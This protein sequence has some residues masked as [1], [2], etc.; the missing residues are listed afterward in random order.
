MTSKSRL[1]SSAT[2]NHTSNF[3]WKPT[4]TGEAV[5]HWFNDDKVSEAVIPEELDGRPVVAAESVAFSCCKSLRSLTL[6]SS[7]RG[8]LSSA[9]A[10]VSLDADLCQRLFGALLDCPSLLKLHVDPKNTRFR[11]VDGVLLTDDGRTLYCF[12]QGRTGDYV[13]PP[14]VERIAPNAFDSCRLT[15]VAF[16]EELRLIDDWAFFKSNNLQTLDFGTKSSLQKIGVRAFG[17][18]AVLKRVTLPD[19][20]ETLDESAFAYSHSL[21]EVILNRS[22]KEIGDGAFYCCDAL[23]QISFGDRL[24]RI[25]SG[26]FCGCSSLTQVV[27][28]QKLYQIGVDAFS[29]CK[30]LTQVVLPQALRKIGASAFEGCKALSSVAF[31]DS[32][33]EIGDRAFEGCKPLTKISLPESLQ[34]INPQTFNACPNLTAF[35]VSPR[36]RFFQVVDGS[37]LSADGKTLWRVPPMQMGAFVVPNGVEEIAPCAFLGCK[38]LAAIE[39]PDSLQTVGDRAFDGCQALAKIA[40]PRNVKTLGEKA[41]NACKSLASL[42][43]APD[44]TLETVGKNAFA[45]CKVLAEISLPPTVNKLGAGAFAKCESLTKAT[46][47]AAVQKKAQNA[48]KGCGALT[49][50]NV[51]QPVATLDATSKPAKKSA[52]KTS[53]KDNDAAS[54]SAPNRQEVFSADGF[55]FA[56]GGKTLTRNLDQTSAER[57]VPE[58]VEKIAVRAFSHC[59]SLKTLKLPSTLKE[60]GTYAFDACEYLE[61]LELPD[62]FETIGER[63][64]FNCHRLRSVSVPA[65]ICKIGSEAFAYCV[66]FAS[67]TYPESVQPKILKALPHKE[68]LRTVIPSKTRDFRSVDGVIFSADGKT[69]EFCSEEKSGAYSVPNGVEIIAEKAFAERQALTSVAF[70]TSLR[71][72]GPKAFFEC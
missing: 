31:P 40:I 28:P 59:M 51:L 61:A 26:A 68:I 36:N 12:P 60:I 56:D 14:G 35:D 19:S 55:L 22:L 72:I 58:G 42:T 50:L 15:S 32:L 27:L 45:G 4:P 20:L 37:L 11:S 44:S 52:K 33:E 21:T 18:C 17:Q 43:F 49:E 30:A 47:P 63:A 53:T 2:P 62:G 46:I 57:V 9:S 24:E 41:F 5:V 66:S 10:V 23:K 48:F 8:F 65:T 6:P 25:G 64:F 70:P 69:L 7:F 67:A 71:Q 39:F 54:S 1:M 16:N 13:V 34:T 38:A 3:Y 29:D